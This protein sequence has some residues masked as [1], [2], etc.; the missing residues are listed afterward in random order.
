[1]AIRESIRRLTLRINFVD[2][3]SELVSLKVPSSV[4]DA[5]IQKELDQMNKELFDKD[6]YGSAGL[7]AE[8]LFRYLSKKHPSWNYEVIEPD[9]EWNDAYPS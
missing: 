8:T 4:T 6:I 9:W 1:M 7:C 2:Y 3:S 5:Q